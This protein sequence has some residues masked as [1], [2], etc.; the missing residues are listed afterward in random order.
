[1]ILEMPLQNILMFSS[2]TEQ[3]KGKFYA[4][5][6]EKL[7][8]FTRRPASQLLTNFPIGKADGI[9]YCTQ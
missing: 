9:N 3:Q 4:F 2:G 1:V 5:T 8:H 7:R 6:L